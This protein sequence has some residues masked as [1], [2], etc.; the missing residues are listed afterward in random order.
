MGLDRHKIV[1]V[2]P[3]KYW[4]LDQMA[5]ALHHKIGGISVCPMATHSSRNRLCLRFSRPSCLALSMAYN[6]LTMLH[7]YWKEDGVTVIKT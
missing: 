4:C 5:L 2:F 6:S 3:K 1:L 7:C